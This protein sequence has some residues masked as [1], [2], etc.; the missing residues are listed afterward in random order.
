MLFLI[1][2]CFEYESVICHEIRHLLSFKKVIE[3]KCPSD[4]IN[5][6]GLLVI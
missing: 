4:F 3:I 1:M 6:K 2:S 5:P